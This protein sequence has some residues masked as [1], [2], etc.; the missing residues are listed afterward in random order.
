MR[1]GDRINHEG[2]KLI[3]I[4]PPSSC[5]GC[6]FWQPHNKWSVSCECKR[7]PEVPH[8]DYAGGNIHYTQEVR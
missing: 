5:Q 4:V 8:C 7:P 2:V 1:V 6:Y 3:A